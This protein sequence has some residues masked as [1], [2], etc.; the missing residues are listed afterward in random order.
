[1]FDNID[2]NQIFRLV[3]DCALRV[4]GVILVLWIGLAIAKKLANKFKDTKAAQKMDPTARSVVA[5]LILWALRIVVIA[6]ICGIL[7]IPSASIVAILGSLGLAIGLAVQGGL[8]NIAGGIMIVLFRPF[9]VGDTINTQGYVGTVTDISLFYTTLDTPDNNVV[10]LPNGSLMNAAVLNYSLKDKRRIDVAISISYK[11]DIDAARKTL[12]ETAA[13]SDLV[14]K[15]PAPVVLVNEH[16]ESAVKLIFRVW[17]ESGKYWDC[18]FGMEEASKKALD[19]A[20]IVI[21]FRQ[22]DVHMIESK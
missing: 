6:M 7:N 18:L 4:L 10:V 13:A 3:L 20:G 21:P 17:C 16:G 9:K 22:L 1:M 14:L 5:N 15:D 19:A 8:S 11:S 12:L 2:L